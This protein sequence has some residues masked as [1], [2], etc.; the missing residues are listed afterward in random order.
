MATVSVCA[1]FSLEACYYD[2][3]WDLYGPPVD[4]GQVEAGYSAVIEPMLSLNCKGCHSGTY[5]DG[6]LLLTTYEEHV[7]AAEMSLERISRPATATGAMP[8]GAPLHPCNVEAFEQWILN[9]K[10]DD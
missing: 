7:A 2:V 9:G 8:P 5:P 6:D 4:C 3:E 1:L 10:L